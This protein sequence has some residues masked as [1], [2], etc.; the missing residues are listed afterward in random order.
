MTGSIRK[1]EKG[2]KTS[3]EVTIDE[4]LDE[5]G[6]RKRRFLTIRGTK[7]D[8]QQALRRLLTDADKGLPVATAKCSLTEFLQSWLKNYAETN[9]GPKTLEGYKEKLRNYVIPKLGTI[10]LPK[11]SPQHIQG[12]YGDMTAKGL[13]PATIIQTHR[14]LREALSHA[15]KWGLIA[16]NVCDATDPP[17][18]I[19][20][21][22]K[23]LDEHGLQRLIGAASGAPYGAVFFLAIH[24]GMRRSEL[25]GLRWKAVDLNSKTLSVVETLQ[26]VKGKGLTVLPTKTHRSRRLIP[27]SPNAAALLSGLKAKRK[28]QLE[29][30]GL[31]WDE[32]EHV[33]CYADGTP[34]RPDAITHAFHDLIKQSSLPS[35]RFHDLR[36]SYASLLLKSKIHPKVVSELLGHSTTTITMDVYSHV[37]PGLQEE[38]AEKFEEML[39]RATP[40][41]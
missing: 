27:L 38:A 28:E 30:L 35:V 12:V 32:A 25:L 17:K 10:P 16:R 14:I 40:G 29:V 21:E 9:V 22:M 13:S 15:I 26:R 39:S 37:L 36:H 1:R 24:T 2:G 20:P 8:A 6:K 4:G 23:T 34:F 11:L 41:L 31:D 5:H 18:L 7:R 33:F 19:R 3:W